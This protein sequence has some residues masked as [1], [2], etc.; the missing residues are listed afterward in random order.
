MT[1]NDRIFVLLLS[2]GYGG[3]VLLML[4]MTLGAVLSALQA[5]SH[6]SLL[7]GVGLSCLAVV[8]CGMF[9]LLVLCIA[10]VFRS[11]GRHRQRER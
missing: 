2:M 1:H 4:G 8:L 3:M 10:D 5:F 11:V 7:G 6:G 9:G